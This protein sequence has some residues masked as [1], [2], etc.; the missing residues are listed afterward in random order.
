M[1]NRSTVAGFSSLIPIVGLLLLTSAPAFAGTVTLKRAFIEKF[2]NR[3]TID[4]SLIVDHAHPHPNAPQADG[5]MHVAGRAQ[6]QVGLPMVAEI[7]NAAAGSETAAVT[8]VHQ[9]EGD[10]QPVAITGV[11]RLWFEHPSTSPQIQ[12]QTV[13]PAQNTNPDHCFEIHPITRFAG[14]A[15]PNSFQFVPG[16]A[17]HDAASSF[18]SYEKLTVTIKATSSAVTIASPKAG[19]NYVDFFIEFA[20]PPKPLDDAGAVALAS[21]LPDA[22]G[23][24]IVENVRVIFVPGTPPAL[25]LAQHPPQQGDRWHV[26]GIPRVSLNAISAF[27]TAGGSSASARKLPYEMIIVGVE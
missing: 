4:A 15:I 17:A 19:F 7:M 24:P 25:R 2:K 11:W 3:A 20:G 23:E 21:V 22:Q 10:N 13:P 1:K 14:I 5:D 26:L 27:V 18:A 9:D 12:F 16:F 8:A 6:Q